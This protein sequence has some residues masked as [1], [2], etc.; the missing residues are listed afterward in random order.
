[1][2]IR[3]NA[4]RPSNRAYSSPAN[5]TS[6]TPTNSIGQLPFVRN[7]HLNAT[8]K[9]ANT[10]NVSAKNATV[11]AGFCASR[12]NTSRFIGTQIEDALSDDN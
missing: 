1:M 12:A 7:A 9:S 8:P 2:N 5:T 4:S 6:G 3:A 11:T 10:G